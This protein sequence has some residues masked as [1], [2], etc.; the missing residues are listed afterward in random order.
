MPPTAEHVHVLA[1]WALLYVVESGRGRV[2]PRVLQ[3]YRPCCSDEG[4]KFPSHMGSCL[5]DRA[6]VP[7]GIAPPGSSRIE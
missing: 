6:L 5:V 3:P 4:W 1:Y 7:A 2:F